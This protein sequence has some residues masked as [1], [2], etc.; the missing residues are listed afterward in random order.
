M[1]FRDAAATGGIR[2]THYPPATGHAIDRRA[3]PARSGQRTGLFR[4]RDDRGTDAAAG[5]ASSGAG[6]VAHVGRFGAEVS[7]KSCRRLPRRSMRTS[8]RKDRSAVSRTACRVNLRLIHAGS[9][10]AVWARTFEQP[11]RN[12]FALQR[13]V[14]QAVAEELAVQLSPAGGNPRR[15]TPRR[16]TNIC[17]AGISFIRSDQRPVNRP[18]HCSKEPRKDGKHARAYAGIAEA[19]LTLGPGLTLCRERR[20]F[21]G[22]R[23]GDPGARAG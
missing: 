17:A 2:A 3:A 6:C 21:G 20:H 15:S 22:P 10:T 11:L 5:D 4:R 14:A 23:R 12:V 8:S 16:M 18:S 13:D 9:D 1:P 19:Y 7:E